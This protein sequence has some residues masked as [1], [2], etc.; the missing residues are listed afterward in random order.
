MGVEDIGRGIGG[1]SY[2]RGSNRWV[3]MLVGEEQVSAEN[4][5]REI[6]GCCC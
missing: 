3:L 5:E 2:H 1:F 4:S 6:G